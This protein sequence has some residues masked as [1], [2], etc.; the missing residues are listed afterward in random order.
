M[1]SPAQFRVRAGGT[2][3]AKEARRH[4]PVDTVSGAILAG[5][6]PAADE[7]VPSLVH[8]RTRNGGILLATKAL[9]HSQ[10]RVR[11]NHF[12]A[13]GAVAV[14]GASRVGSNGAYFCLCIPERSPSLAA[15]ATGP[16]SAP[17]LT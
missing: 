14:A 3:L 15:G 17:G 1:R 6:R 12:C 2:I 5:Q 16:T 13:R 9:L 7:H 10:A 4:S 11:G 8:P